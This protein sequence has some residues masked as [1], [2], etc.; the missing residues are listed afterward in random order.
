M[1]IRRHI[2]S[3]FTLL[4]LFLGFLSILQTQAHHFENACYIILL[5][6]VFDSMDGKLARL[7]GNSSNFGIEIDSLA[8]MVSFCLAPSV[9]IYTL[10]THDM[11]GLSGELIASAPLIVGAVRL[12]RFN[13]IQGEKPTSYFVGLPTP[14][15]ALAIASLVLFTE[16]IKAVNPEYTQPRLLL[17]IIFTIS[18]LMVSKIKYAKF[19][20]LSFKHSTLNSQ[21]LVGVMIFTVTFITGWFYHKASWVLLGFLTYYIL[22][23]L[24][25][26]LLNVDEN[27]G[28][29]TSHAKTI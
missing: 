26:R 12:A 29:D 15:M 4:N 1:K 23:G 16:N 7:F 20:I 17:P 9:L 10:Y 3:L 5:A 6:G 22:S 25:R 28:T 21:R 19:P 27:E 8:D 24:M 14:I 13:V 18:F 2:P 11:P